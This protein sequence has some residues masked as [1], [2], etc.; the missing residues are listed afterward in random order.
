MARLLRGVLHPCQMQLKQLPVSGKPGSGVR[1]C[2]TKS[3]SSPSVRIACAS[4]FWGDT[5]TAVPQLVYGAQVMI[6]ECFEI[7]FY[8]SIVD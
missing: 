5:P 2:Q 8:S 6:G 4:G 7:H 1:F 3:E